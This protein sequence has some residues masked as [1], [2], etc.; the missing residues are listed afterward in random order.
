MVELVAALI[1]FAAAH[2]APIAPR[3]RERTVARLGRTVYLLAYSVMS[4]AL[5]AWVVLAYGRAPF[6]ELWQAPVWWRWVAIALMLPV[7]VILILGM[8][9]PRPG[10][11][12]VYALARHPAMW[13]LTAWAAI[14]VVANGDAA[15]ALMFATFGALAVPGALSAQA[16]WRKRMGEDSWRAFLAA[17]SPVPFA[18]L[19]RGRARFALADVDPRAAVAAVAVYG[20]LLLLHGPVIGIDLTAFD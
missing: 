17:T 5:L 13:A 1:L 12:G 2:A 15:T 16:R 3:V 4:L 10:R 7:V 11:L 8:R 6:V 20:A 19:A 9:T 18:A 14:H